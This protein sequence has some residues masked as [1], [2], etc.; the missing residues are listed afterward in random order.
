MLPTKDETVK[1]D[2][3]IF[4]YEN[5]KTLDYDFFSFYRIFHDKTKKGKENHKYNET[6]S[7]FNEFK[8]RLKS[9]QDRFQLSAGLNLEKLNTVLSETLT[10]FKF[11]LR[12]YN[13]RLLVSQASC[14]VG[15]PVLQWEPENSSYDFNAMQIKHSYCAT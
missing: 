15:N 7:E 4:K 9:P 10:I 6:E 3:K 2:L 5:S 12:Q 13:F 1:I 8:P 14:F 11:G